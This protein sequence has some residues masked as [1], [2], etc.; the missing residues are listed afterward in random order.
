MEFLSHYH[1]KPMAG[2]HQKLDLFNSPDTDF[3]YVLENYLRIQSDTPPKFNSER[4]GFQ[5]SSLDQYLDL[6]DSFVRFLVNIRE[7]DGTALT[8]TYIIAPENLFF[9]TFLSNVAITVNGVQLTSSFDLYPYQAWI[10]TQLQNEFEVKS[11]TLSEQIFFPGN[12][13]DD[14]SDTNLSFKTRLDLAKW[15]KS[16]EMIGRQM[17]GI[18]NNEKFFPPGTT[19]TIELD[20]KKPEFALCGPP[21]ATT[22]YKI[23]VEIAEFYVRRAR[24]N[25][26][27]VASIQANFNKKKYAS[28]SYDNFML[29]TSIVPEKTRELYIPRIIHGTILPKL[30]CF[31][32]I[33]LDAYNGRR[34]K[35]PFNF[36]PHG[37]CNMKLEFEGKAVVFEELNFE[38][39]NFMMTYNNLSKLLPESNGGNDIT[40]EQFSNG[41]TLFVFDTQRLRG[42]DYNASRIGRLGLDLRFAQE[43]TE[44]LQIVIVSIEEAAIELDGQGRAQPVSRNTIT[45]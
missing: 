16:F 20:T 8:A 44:Q 3:S 4:I 18:F 14:F 22:T 12:K 28:Y 39:G 38:N 21:N 32:F 30:I 36:K 31:G 35:L 19:F 45:F 17:H 11:S 33:P 26:K 9:H 10:F 24:V 13:M 40:Y 1:S 5:F 25:P 15:S 42:D 41:N 43:T 29:S 7:N 6:S 34:E 27:L 23:Q 37:V 2:T